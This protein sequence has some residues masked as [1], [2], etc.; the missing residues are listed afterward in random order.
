MAKLEVGPAAQRFIA[1]LERYV[2]KLHYGPRHGWT[3]GVQ[4]AQHTRT[5]RRI[6]VGPLAKARLLTLRRKVV[7]VHYSEKTGFWVSVVAAGLSQRQVAVKYANEALPFAGRMVYDEGPLRAE[8]FNHSPGDYDG[9]HADCS[10]FV[11]AIMHWAGITTVDQWDDTGT[12]LVKGKPVKEPGIGRLI[13][14][15]PGTGVHVGM[16][17]GR[18]DGVWEIVEFGKQAAPDRISLD[19][20]V[21]YFHSIGVGEFRYRDFF[22]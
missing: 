21:A 7:K 20:F 17:V 16:F 10:Q 2:V 14:A 19:A 3:V 9:A 6:E 12:L 18:A 22:E 4:H 13:I 11:S 5:N 8:L 1:Q 15:G